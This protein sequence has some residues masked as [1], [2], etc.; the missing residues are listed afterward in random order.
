M[1]SGKFCDNCNKPL[2]GYV[3]DSLLFGFHGY[4]V[5]GPIFIQTRDFCCLD[6]LKEFY[7]K[8]E[9]EEEENV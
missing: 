6:C 3:I 1:A 4:S 2:S 7:S 9:E 5:K 8:E